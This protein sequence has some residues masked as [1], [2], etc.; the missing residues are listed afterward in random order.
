M[1]GRPSGQI[2]HTWSNKDGPFPTWSPHEQN[3]V[4][5]SAEQSDQLFIALFPGAFVSEQRQF[6][7]CGTTIASSFRRQERLARFAL[8]G[9]A[10]Q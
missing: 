5:L 4:N 1:P 2:A 10:P 6:A 3:C 9:V 7:Q 8:F